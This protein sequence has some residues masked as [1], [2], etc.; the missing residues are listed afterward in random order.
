MDWEAIELA[1]GTGKNGNGNGNG[2]HKDPERNGKHGGNG[3][4]F[5]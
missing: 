4:L 2:K 1:D 3:G 5:D